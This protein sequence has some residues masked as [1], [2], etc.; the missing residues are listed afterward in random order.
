MTVK[1]VNRITGEVMIEGD[2]WTVMFL[3]GR[4]AAKM[5]YLSD[6]QL[7]KA[8]KIYFGIFPDNQTKT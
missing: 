2:F 1:N 5:G 3:G 8:Y 6:L 4:I 7:K